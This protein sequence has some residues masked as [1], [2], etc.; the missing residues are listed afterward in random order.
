M[1]LIV[2]GKEH[3]KRTDYIKKA[4]DSLHVPIELLSWDTLFKGVD[5]ECLK[6]AS[7]KIDPPSYQIV[8]LSQMQKQLTDYQ[9]I[10]QQLMQADC[11]F[12]NTPAAICQMLDKKA[13]KQCLQ[14]HKVPVTQMFMEAVEST[15]QL[16][17]VMQKRHCYSVFVKPR[18]FSGAAG[19]AAFRFQPR[20][21]KMILYTSCRLEEGQLINTKKLFKLENPIK[22]EQLLNKLLCLDCVVERWHPK[23]VYQN[24]SYDLRVVF[25]F[26]HIA[27]IVVR[28]SAGPVTNLH[29][30]NQA[31]DI[32]ALKLREETMQE[33]EAVCRQAISFYPGLHMAGIDILLEK[34]T[35]K[36]LIIEMNGQGDL[37]YQDIFG[38]NKIYQEQ[39][40]YLCRKSI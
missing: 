22:I 37:I 8:H 6:G 32:Q 34:E 4:A 24:K 10:L 16:L 27:H 21:G 25:Q 35:L 2:I 17:A 33:I 18:F 13:A 3:S 15:E 39:V 19:T 12:L 26:D 28:Q 9:N 7:V 40:K 11:R 23:S 20:Q 36:P 31:L 30:N 1:K 29:L 14:A 38:D 5:V